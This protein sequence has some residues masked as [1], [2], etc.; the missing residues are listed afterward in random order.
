MLNIVGKGEG[1]YFQFRCEKCNE[2]LDCEYL[3]YERAMPHFRATCPKCKETA[4]K[5]LV[6]THWKGL[7]A[8]PFIDYH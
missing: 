1:D 4:E 6:R 3:G 8:E 7:P 5:K 2:I